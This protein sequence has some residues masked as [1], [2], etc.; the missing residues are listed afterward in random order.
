MLAAASVL[1]V[2]LLANPAAAGPMVSRK[3]L[4]PFST[5]H[6]IQGNTKPTSN[7]CGSTSV[8]APTSANRSN[9]R[10]SMWL[11]ANASGSPC[12]YTASAV[13]GFMVPFAVP[14][15]GIHRVAVNWTLTWN[16]SVWNQAACTPKTCIHPRWSTA[17]AE[18]DLYLLVIDRTSNTT[19][20]S[21][22]SP[23][24]F[25]SLLDGWFACLPSLRCRST[26]TTSLQIWSGG[27]LLSTHHYEVKTYVRISVAVTGNSYYG[28]QLSSG[29]W[30]DFASPG[31]GALNWVIVR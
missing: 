8:V 10:I 23:V 31:G 15:N 25:V 12:T 17:A 24:R 28:T 19:V 18:A 6:I 11:S 1:V 26:G 13:A 5:A 7:W 21:H 4:P 27:N 29:A 3:L 22:S 9:G 20:S 2:L 14:S 30:F 16:A